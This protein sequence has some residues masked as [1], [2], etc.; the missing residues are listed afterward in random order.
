MDRNQK[1]KL[2]DI[3]AFFLKGLSPQAG[4][5]LVASVASVLSEGLTIE[6]IVALA[7]FMGSISQMMAYIAAQTALNANGKQPGITVEE[8]PITLSG[9]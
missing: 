5:F 3:K 6:E 7:S 9:I 4:P 1:E 8:T 2:K